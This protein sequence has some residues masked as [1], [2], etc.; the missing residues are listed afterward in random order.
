MNFDQSSQQ[1]LALQGGLLD[2]LSY[3]DE[4]E[5]LRLGE[6]VDFDK[7]VYW[8]HREDEEMTKTI[9]GKR[10]QPETGCSSTE[11][12]KEKEDIPPPNKK[13]KKGKV[14]SPS[15]WDGEFIIIL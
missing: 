7:D 14:L 8:D 15:S 12:G 3:S 13:D 1:E 9:L 11:K 4:G 10:K 5:V 6:D 2:P